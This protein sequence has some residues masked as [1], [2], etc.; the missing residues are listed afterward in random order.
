MEVVSHRGAGVL[1]PENTLLAIRKG[2]EL[3]AD[4]VE[5]DVRATKD[6][7]LVLMHDAELERTTNSTGKLS[8]KTF[9][10]LKDVDAGKGEKIPLFSEALAEVKG[11]LKIEVEI[12]EAGIEGLVVK[13]IE[14]A[15]MEKDVLVISFFHTALKK[16]KELNPEIRTAVILFAQPIDFGSLIKEANADAVHT[17]L[18]YAD[19]EI[20]DSL[21]VDGKELFISKILAEEDFG[22]AK[23][24]G[25]TGVS[26]DNPDKII[27]LVKS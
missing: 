27:P 1:E 6:R 14:A 4:A 7:K 10:E 23:E 11:K 19:R 22:K 5:I 21:K 8:E 18:E 13:E 3:G 16:V 25:A 12:K 20:A 9:G 15:G 26:T 17:K 2:I 24:M